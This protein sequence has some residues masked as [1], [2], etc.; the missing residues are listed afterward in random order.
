MKINDIPDGV[1]PK[2]KS[3]YDR[4][5]VVQLRKEYPS[6][7]AFFDVFF[8]GEEFDPAFLRFY[9]EGFDVRAVYCYKLLVEILMEQT[10]GLSEST[11]SEDLCLMLDKFE[12]RGPLTD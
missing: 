4:D 3:Q 6:M 11:A 5:P 7:D 2:A 1:R 9:Q 10:A 8:L 12:R